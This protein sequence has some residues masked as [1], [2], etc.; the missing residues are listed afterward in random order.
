M[1]NKKMLY[2]DRIDV[3]ERIDVNSASE[4]EECDTVS[5]LI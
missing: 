5:P 1:I 2:F 3:S 4:S